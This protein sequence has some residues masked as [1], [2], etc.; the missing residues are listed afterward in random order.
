[1]AAIS[2]LWLVPRARVILSTSTS[3]ICKSDMQLH[4]ACGQ[5]KWRMHR[6]SGLGNTEDV[7]YR[8]QKAFLNGGGGGIIACYKDACYKEYQCTRTG[9]PLLRI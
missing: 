8:Q 6:G 1:M 5:Q 4:C 2:R 9:H 7:A 3:L